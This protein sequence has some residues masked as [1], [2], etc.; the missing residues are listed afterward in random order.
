MIYSLLQDKVLIM[1]KTLKK[2]EGGKMFSA[3]LS[4]HH[5]LYTSNIIGTLHARVLKLHTLFPHKKVSEPY[6]SCPIYL[7]FL[8]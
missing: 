8:N 7:Q 5:T 6:F 2:L 4:F 3:C 1:P